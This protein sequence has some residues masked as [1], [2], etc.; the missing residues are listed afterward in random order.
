MR[1]VKNI[2]GLIILITLFTLKSHAQNHNLDFLNNIDASEIQVA[3]KTFQDQ[4]D[5]VF[6]DKLN[7]EV[8]FRGYN[9]SGSAKLIDQEFKPFKTTADAVNSFNL[10]RKQAGSNVV[11]FLVMWEGVQPDQNVI[12]Y[13]YLDDI[14]EQTKAAIENGI[15][16]MYNYH[17]TN[18]SRY[19]FQSTNEFTGNGAPKYIIDGDNYSRSNC[20]LCVLSWSVHSQLDPAITEGTSNFW[21][22]NVVETS[23]GKKRVLDEFY[24]QMSVFTTYLKQNLTADE[25]AFI[26]G[27]NPFNEP[28]SGIHDITIQEYYNDYLWPFN[29][30]LRE[31]MDNTSWENKLVFAEPEVIWNTNLEIPGIID[32]HGNGLVEEIPG[33]GFVFNSHLYDALRTADLLGSLTGPFTFLR[34]YDDIREE[35]RNLNNPLLISEFGFPLGDVGNR[36]RIRNVESHYSGIENQLTETSFETK[37]TAFYSPLVPAMEWHWDINYNLHNEY[38]NFNP[39]RIAVEYD[40][41]NSENFSVINPVTGEYTTHFKQVER[42]YIRRCQGNLMH[43]SYNA[44]P[45]DYSGNQLNWKALKVP[46]D[47]QERF[48]NKNF[49]IATWQGNN[50][51]APTEIYIPRHFKLDKTVVITDKKIYSIGE[52]ILQSAPTNEL[53]ELLVLKDSG[54]DEADGYRFF[55]WDDIDED[56]SQSSYHFAFI[57]NFDDD[58]I[59]NESLMQLQTDL[60]TTINAEK[61]PVVLK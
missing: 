55:I 3:E 23:E 53:N 8:N 32:P 46:E 2:V 11:R 21:K 57:I 17:F 61:H 51:N 1:F 36:D 10:L 4:T 30:R 7:R 40:G 33:D 35:G 27:I 43:F 42:A 29:K 15:Y 48:S 13:S 54:A 14:V 34:D 19:L 56:E 5:W 47:G 28:H 22:N 59:S 26:V 20:P 31:V 50:S 58:L 45:I 6:R 9:V 41:W 39:D 38:I 49:T 37:R 44:V 16:V 18:Y 25:F 52:V 24:Y 60:I 12:D